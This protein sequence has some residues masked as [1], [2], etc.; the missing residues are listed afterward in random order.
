MSQRVISL[1]CEFS[2]ARVMEGT[3]YLTDSDNP[4]TVS[5]TNDAE[6][7][8]RWAHSQYPGKRVMYRDSDGVWDQ[9]VHVDGIF[10]KFQM[11]NSPHEEGAW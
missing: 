7:V 5:M 4:G 9:M 1:R 10:M 3:I 8:C 11:G 6:S 2:V